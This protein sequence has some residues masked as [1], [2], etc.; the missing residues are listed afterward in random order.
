MIKMELLS[1][2]NINIRRGNTEDVFPITHLTKT[3]I[4]SQISGYEWPIGPVQKED[5]TSDEDLD[6]NSF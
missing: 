3:L 1:L 4:H 6:R 2:S 5:D